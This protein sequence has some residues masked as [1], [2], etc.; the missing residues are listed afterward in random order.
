M[1]VDFDLDEGILFP[2]PV[3]KKMSSQ[4]F[5]AQILS[6]PVPAG[7]VGLWFLGQNG[8]YLK[9]SDGG[10]VVIDPYLTDFCGSK[11]T[12]EKKPKSRLLPVFIEPEDLQAD[13]VL[14][15][16]SHADH[17]DPYTLERLSIKT[18]ARFF[19]PY[20]VLPFLAEAGIP[21][22]QTQLMHPHQAVEWRDWEIRGTFALP[23]DTTDLNHMGYLIKAPGGKVFYN[24]GDTAK[25]QLLA[26]VASA[27]PDVMTVCINGGYHNLSH[28]EAAEITALVKPRIV[29]PA[30]YD[31][32]PHNLQS[33]HM[34]RKSL[35]ENYPQV[36]YKKMDY[37]QPFFF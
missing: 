26:H 24:T 13:L 7:Q 21:E 4:E 5:M 37:Y 12:G 16:H 20:Q 17:C 9:G 8:F 11:R 32:M 31:M 6:T 18:K 23:T 29:I 25:C 10:S 15:T 33:P 35:W 1:T 28:W 22:G 3:E 36:E 2:Q 19:G 27:K 34:F 30:H 14:L